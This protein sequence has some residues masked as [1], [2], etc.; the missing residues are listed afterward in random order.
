MEDSV[1]KQVPI[2][3][4]T[5]INIFFPILFPTNLLHLMIATH[6]GWIILLKIKSNGN[7]K[8]T[9][10]TKKYFKLQ[11]ATNVVSEVINRLREEYQNHLA[12]NLD[13]PMTNPITFLSLIVHL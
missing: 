7:T 11:E 4:E 9:K 5:I 6:F 1:N 10:P 8:Y 12:L 13:D 3:N 2:F